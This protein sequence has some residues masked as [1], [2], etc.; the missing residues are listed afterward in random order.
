MPLAQEIRDA[1]AAVER[2]LDE[3]GVRAFVYT[4]EQKEGGWVLS[5]ECAT[6]GGWQKVA[7]GVDLAALS[8]SLEDAAL[9]AKLRAA[10]A[11]HLSA[12]AG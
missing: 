6:N 1:R 3:L 11:P 12:C 5:V 4:L 10:W 9:R 2:I 7:L 8:A